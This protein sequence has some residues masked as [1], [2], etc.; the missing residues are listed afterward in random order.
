[1]GSGQLIATI[2]SV[3]IILVVL[4]LIWFLYR[5]SGSAAQHEEA[6]QPVKAAAIPVKEEAPRAAPQAAPVV[7]AKAVEPPPCD[8]LTVL[9]GIGP[10]V[11]SLLQKAGITTFAKLAETDPAAISEILQA[12]R[13]Q[14][15]DPH[16][17]PDQARLAAAGD[18]AGLKA[19]QD[20][21]KG[22]RVV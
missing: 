9:E 1:M 15:L 18:A 8:D 14:M 7:E 22:G 17:W 3:L 5:R 2:V 11:N 10:K 16:S 13:L 21:L 6:A 12:N 19:L 4:F 20:K